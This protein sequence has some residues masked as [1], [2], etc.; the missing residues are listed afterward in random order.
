[1][2]LNLFATAALITGAMIQTSVAHEIQISTNRFG[3]LFEDAS[4]PADLQTLIVSDIQRCY[5]AW[6]TSVTFEPNLPVRHG[7]YI[8]TRAF[9]G[10]YC[11]DRRIIDVPED[12]VTN[13][14]G[15]LSL[16]VP[17]V[18]IQK[19]SDAL[20]FKSNNLEKV[21]AADAFVGMGSMKLH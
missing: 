19:Y 17:S 9:S 20:A 4:L 16:M 14:V 3:V 7:T 11:Y 10:P 5:D 12:I 6:G 13:A 2:K 15:Q 8:R 18:V 21:M 1:M